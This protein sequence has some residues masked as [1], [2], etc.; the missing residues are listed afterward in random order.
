MLVVF[1]DLSIDGGLLSTWL[2]HYPGEFVRGMLS[3]MCSWGSHKTVFKKELSLKANA[4]LVSSNQI[5]F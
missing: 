3:A 5:D 4:G 2:I 1:Y